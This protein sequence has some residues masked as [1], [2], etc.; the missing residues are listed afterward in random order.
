MLKSIDPRSPELDR[1]MGKRRIALH[2][3]PRKRGTAKRGALSWRLR[4]VWENR[5]DFRDPGKHQK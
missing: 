3:G 1:T 2:P 5:R 4:R